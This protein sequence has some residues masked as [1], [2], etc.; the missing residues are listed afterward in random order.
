MMLK[1][2][3]EDLNLYLVTFQLW[4]DAYIC[5]RYCHLQSIL[6]WKVLQISKTFN[7]KLFK[8]LFVYERE[9]FHYKFVESEQTVIICEVAV[10]YS[11]D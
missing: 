2:S 6:A 7:K 1:N 4:S 10:V 11:E 3:Q 8:I 5:W 9:N